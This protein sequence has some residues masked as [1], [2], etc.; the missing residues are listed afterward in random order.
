MEESFLHFIW[1][2]QKFRQKPLQTNEGI[3][4]SVFDPGTKNTDAGPD[5]K[6]ARIQ[7]GEIL[8]HGHV[9]IHVAAADWKRH[10]HQM[11][12]AY[13]NVILHVVWKNDEK[14]YR[15]DKSPIPTLE[16]NGLVEDEII[17]RYRELLRPENDIL[18]KRF[19][20]NVKK[21]TILGMLDN[22]LA[23]RLKTRS[24]RIFRDVGLT[25]NN[26][27]E[28]AWRLLTRNFGFKTNTEP[29]GELARST[30]IKILKKELHSQF[31][32]EAILFGQA[33]FL[34]DEPMDD[35]HERLQ[36]EYNFKAHKYGLQRRLDYHQ[37]KFLR[38]RPA[39]FPTIRIAQISSLLSAHPNLFSLFSNYQNPKSLT[40]KL[41][42]RQIDYWRTH[43]DFGKRSSSRLGVLGSSSIDNILINTVAPMQFA[44]GVHKD[45]E[46]LKENALQLLNYIKPEKNSIIKKW[47]EAGM[48]VGSAFDS[49]ALLEQYNEY[50]LNKQCLNCQVGAEIIS[51]A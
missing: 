5:F 31:T 14:A 37:W 44:Y 25:D 39:N 10:N 19:L 28:I 16:L 24:A 17:F 48:Q 3:E 18:C 30:P 27:E 23:R 47:I 1:K 13:D 2:F 7:I 26:W 49:Q 21:L 6:N 11:D 33:G 8:W 34:N 51:S 42:V 35:Y 12:Q 43:Y 32:I 38:L 15:K 22:A 9:E 36:K 40:I 29:F 46:A 41:S 45:N 20:P 4:I 50:C